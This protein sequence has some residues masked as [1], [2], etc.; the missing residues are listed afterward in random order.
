MNFD[1]SIYIPAFNAEN[2]I[3]KCLNSIFKQT[4]YPMEILVINDCSTDGTSRILEK[5]N[6]KIK[7]I[8]N[9]NNLGLSYSMNIANK[10]LKTRY[11]AKIDADVELEADWLEKNLNK[12]KSKNNEIT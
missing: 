1:V 6:N 8:N 11:I 10:N 5:Y 7:V 9:K 3:D 12:L 2:T 4:V